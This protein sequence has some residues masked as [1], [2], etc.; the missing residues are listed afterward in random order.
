METL[1]ELIDRGV[2]NED[3]RPMAPRGAIMYKAAS[4]QQKQL[5]KALRTLK[6]ARSIIYEVYPEVH[7]Y[8]DATDEKKKRFDKAC[9]ALGVT[10]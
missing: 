2:I 7:E 9:K 6:L 1:R 8:T 3:P 5:R 10:K 4:A